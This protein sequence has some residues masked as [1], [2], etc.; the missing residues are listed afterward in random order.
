MNGIIDFNRCRWGDMVHGFIK[1]AY[2]TRAISIP[3][4]VGQIEGYNG[5]SPTP[6]FWEKYCLY[7]AQMIIPDHLWAYDYAVKSGSQDE[8]RRSLTRI[9][10]VYF[11]HEGFR[12]D[13]PVSYRDY[14]GG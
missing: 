6:G 13:I 4:S 10:M 12:T 3:F 7:C 11:D 2:F 8:I 9:Q 5:G 14:T 1:V